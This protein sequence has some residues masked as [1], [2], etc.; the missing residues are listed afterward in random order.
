M[1]HA[2]VVLGWA[3]QLLSRRKADIIKGAEEISQNK[4]GRGHEPY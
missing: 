1:I 3:L 4:E 2:F